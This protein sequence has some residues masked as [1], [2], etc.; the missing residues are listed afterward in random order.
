[1][2]FARLSD[3]TVL[4]G[5]KSITTINQSQTLTRKLFRCTE[6]FNSTNRKAGIVVF[7]L[8]FVLLNFLTYETCERCQTFKIK[9]AAAAIKC[10]FP[11]SLSSEFFSIQRTQND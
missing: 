8:Y 2:Y 1:M 6:D 4:G 5:G 10:H 3:P 9:Q 7:N 11:F